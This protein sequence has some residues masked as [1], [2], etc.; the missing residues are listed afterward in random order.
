M[1]LFIYFQV[2]ENSHEKSILN[3]YNNSFNC[4]IECF[5][6]KQKEA[7]KLMVQDQMDVV[8]MLPTVYV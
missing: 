1:L 6:S 5:K 3:T 4:N 8:C 7:I 2:D